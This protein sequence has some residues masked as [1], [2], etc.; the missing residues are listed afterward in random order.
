MQIR[1]KINAKAGN[2]P[3]ITGRDREITGNPRLRAKIAITAASER[4]CNHRSH[5]RVPLPPSGE[6]LPH[7]VETFA[8]CTVFLLPKSKKPGAVSARASDKISRLHFLTR[9]A[10]QVNRVLDRLGILRR[11]DPSAGSGFAQPEKPL[12]SRNPDAARGVRCRPV[13]QASTR[14]TSGNIQAEHPHFRFRPRRAR[15]MLNPGYENSA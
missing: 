1:K 10:L 12:S 13:T 9:V 4:S 6:A 15:P 7:F 14:A 2:L 3:K 8:A 11:C 5:W